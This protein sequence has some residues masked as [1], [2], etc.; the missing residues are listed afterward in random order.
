[1]LR[2]KCEKILIRFTIFLLQVINKINLITKDFT[3]RF[4]LNLVKQ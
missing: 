3:Q 1:M 4:L 2:G